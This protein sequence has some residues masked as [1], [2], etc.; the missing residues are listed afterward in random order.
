MVGWP[1]P[2]CRGAGLS[3][4]EGQPRPRRARATEWGRRE[5]G[6][7]EGRGGRARRRVG[8]GVRWTGRWAGQRGERGGG[9]E[10]GEEGPKKVGPHPHATRSPVLYRPPLAAVH[11]PTPGRARAV[12][13]SA[14]RQLLVPELPAAPDTLSRTCGPYAR[15]EPSSLFW[16]GERRARREPLGNGDRVRGLRR[17]GSRRPASSAKVA[18]AACRQGGQ[19]G[20][21]P[22]TLACRLTLLWVSRASP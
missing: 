19:G 4:R 13:E 22:P 2:V 14:R 18:P 5:R 15:R 21:G 9:V 16:L 20:R 8:G 1:P 10:S 7:D 11:G 12:T 17:V 3:L 6:G